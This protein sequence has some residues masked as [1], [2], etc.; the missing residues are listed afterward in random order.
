MSGSD[1]TCLAPRLLNQLTPLLPARR[2][3]LSGAAAVGMMLIVAS[4]P[5]A[6]SMARR[7]GS[8]ISPP[9]SAPPSNKIYPAMRWLLCVKQ[10]WYWVPLLQ[11][12]LL[13]KDQHRVVVLSPGYHSSPILLRSCRLRI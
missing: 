10:I 13:S 8:D 6:S 1:S 9:N 7:S 12:I 5:P 11:A 2:W 4:G 3:L